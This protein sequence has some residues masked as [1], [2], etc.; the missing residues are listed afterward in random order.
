M[1]SKMSQLHAALEEQLGELGFETLDQAAE[2]GWGIDYEAQK[3]VPPMYVDTTGRH[4]LLDHFLD[5][6]HQDW[7]KE[8]DELVAELEAHFAKANY[9]NED[10]A[11]TLARAIEF[12]KRSSM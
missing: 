11:A 4:D 10:I 5:Q 3:L 1:C 12:I 6:A 9:G 7:E 2:A 8:R